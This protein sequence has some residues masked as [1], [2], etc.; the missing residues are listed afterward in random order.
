METFHQ[1]WLWISLLFSIFKQRF[2]GRFLSLSTFKLETPS[3][4]NL[5]QSKTSPIGPKPYSSLLC[6]NQYEIAKFCS[7]V[8]MEYYRK[9][10]E[11]GG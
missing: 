6:D 4:P 7:P 10:S 5:E 1:E 3:R 2:L 9:R 11:R 8:R